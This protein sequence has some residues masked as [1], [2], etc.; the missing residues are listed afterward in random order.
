MITTFIYPPGAGWFMESLSI[1]ESEFSPIEW[2]FQGNL[3]LDDHVCDQKTRRRLRLLGAKE[4][5]SREEEL[6]QLSSRV[7]DG[8]K[9]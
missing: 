8:R 7:D 2:I 9:L 6:R 1:R 5:R 4:L 3:W